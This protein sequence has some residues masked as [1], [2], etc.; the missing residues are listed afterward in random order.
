MRVREK[1]F[2]IANDEKIQT[3]IQK[4]KQLL[5]CVYTIVIPVVFRFN[6]ENP[7]NISDDCCQSSG[8]VLKTE[9]RHH[10]VA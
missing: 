3:H 9:R 7:C 6:A 10:A 4:K 8:S 1:E 5:R 2:C